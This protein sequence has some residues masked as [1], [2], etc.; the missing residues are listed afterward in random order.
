MPEFHHVKGFSQVAT[1]VI[2][3]VSVSNAQWFSLLHATCV[4]LF[5]SIIIVINKN[6]VILLH[7]STASS[8]TTRIAGFLLR[9]EHGS[10]RQMSS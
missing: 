1:Y 9:S 6:E 2:V 3:R 4:I 5:R 10:I 7:G 8:K